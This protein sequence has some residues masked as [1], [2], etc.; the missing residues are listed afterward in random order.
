MTVYDFAET[1]EHMARTLARA[2]IVHTGD[3]A[4]GDHGT[5][6]QRAAAARAFG[7]RESE[8]AERAVAYRADSTPDELVVDERDR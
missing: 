1:L 3:H 6:L 2:D 7:K 4:C 5:G 8:C